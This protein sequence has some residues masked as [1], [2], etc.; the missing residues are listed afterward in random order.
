MKNIRPLHNNVVVKRSIAPTR[1]GNIYVPENAADN[2]KPMEGVVVAVGKGVLDES[3]NLKPLD[4]KTGD[5]VLFAKWGGTEVEL[6]SENSVE[7]EK[8][9]IMKESDILAVVEEAA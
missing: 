8:Y 4:V 7:K 6:A 3:N 2:E 1:V 9:L 5:T